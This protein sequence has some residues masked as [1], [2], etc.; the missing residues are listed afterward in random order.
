M[1]L[2]KRVTSYSSSLIL[3][4]FLA[5]WFHVIILMDV[6]KIPSEEIPFHS[7]YLI[8]F[9]QQRPSKYVTTYILTEAIKTFFTFNDSCQ[10]G[11]SDGT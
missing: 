8:G 7:Q 3:V 10:C 1:D 5:L 11:L 6:R 9:H 2:A 4:P